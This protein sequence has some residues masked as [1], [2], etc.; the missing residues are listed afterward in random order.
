[1]DSRNLVEIA[2]RNSRKRAIIVAAGAIVFV[3]GQALGGP[4][5][6]DTADKAL[7]NSR[8]IMWALNVVLLLAFLATGGGLL[9]NPQIRAL[10]NDEVS[11]ANYR[12]SVIAGFWVAMTSALVLYLVPV[13]AALTAKQTLYLVLTSSV[14]VASLMFAYLELRAHRDA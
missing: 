2:D 8:T 9:N 5:F 4:A 10:V 14:A 13:F 6:S 11:R 7:Y 3:A 1:M 12:T